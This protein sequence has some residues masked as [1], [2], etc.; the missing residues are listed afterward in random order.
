[1]KTFFEV[2]TWLFLIALLVLIAP[3]VF[4]ILVA[5]ILFVAE[6]CLYILIFSF[7]VHLFEEMFKSSS[8][9]DRVWNYA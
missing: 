7:V 5:C 3:V 6:V 8:P 2:L 1:M 4:E 9:S